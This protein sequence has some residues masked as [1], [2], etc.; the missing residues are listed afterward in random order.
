MAEEISGLRRDYQLAQLKEDEMLTD[1]IEQFQIWL[2]QVIDWGIKDPTAMTVATVSPDG[3]P[4]QRIVLLKQVDER[5][6]VFYTNYES[7]KAQ[8]LSINNKISLHF[9]WHFAERQVKVCGVAQKVSTAESLKYFSS[10]PE[11]S[12]LAA[13][14]SSQSRPIDSRSMLMAQFARM[15]DKF[16]N[17]QI[18]LPDFWGGYRVVPHEIEFWQGGSHRLHDRLVYQKNEQNQWLMSRLMP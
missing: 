11:E 16:K 4:S 1:P 17:G 13:W 6:F 10:R 14:A 12:Q 2:K 9:P 15:K 8:E 18:P 5:G 3:Q 7:R